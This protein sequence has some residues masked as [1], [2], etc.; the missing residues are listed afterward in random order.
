M[1]FDLNEL[2]DDD[3]ETISPREIESLAQPV[4]ESE[5][6]PLVSSKA[7]EPELARTLHTSGNLEPAIGPAHSAHLND[8]APINLGQH[9]FSCFRPFVR[10]NVKGLLGEE[11][12]QVVKEYNQI[13]DFKG[14]KTVKVENALVKSVSELNNG[15][16][17]SK[18]EG[19]VHS[20]F[21][22]R[23]QNATFSLSD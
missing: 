3:S 17:H 12:S 16:G 2:P 8:T 15:H 19:C 20:I 18:S 10:S 13:D 7:P 21:E 11:P 23:S 4:K 1:M 5:L 6:Q 22:L 9:P 14:P